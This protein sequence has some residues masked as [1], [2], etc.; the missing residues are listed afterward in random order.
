MYPPIYWKFIAVLAPW[1]GG[2]WER[3]I[4][5]N[6]NA[7]KHCLERSS[8]SYEELFTVPVEVEAIVNWLTQLGEDAEDAEA[9]TPSHFLTGKRVVELQASTRGSLPSSTAH[10]WRSRVRYR[11]K[12]LHRLWTRWK[13]EYLL[14]LNSAN[15]CQPTSSSQLHVGDLAFVRDDNV[16]ALQ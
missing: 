1:R 4:R 12:L 2:F 9:L 8:V 5:T 13:N 6:K 14:L 11:D 16:P 3:V 15:H 7:L 10:E